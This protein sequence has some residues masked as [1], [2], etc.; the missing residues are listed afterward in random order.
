MLNILLE[1]VAGLDIKTK[2]VSEVLPIAADGTPAKKVFP[3]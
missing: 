3:R 1:L 2:G